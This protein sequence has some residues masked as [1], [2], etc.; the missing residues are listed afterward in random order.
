MRTYDHSLPLIVI[1]V[2]KTG[3][4][5]V[6]TF[7]TEWFGEDL[8][9]HYF[10]HQRGLMPRK[11]DLHAMNQIAGP[12]VVYGHFNRDRGFGVEDYY[13]DAK[14]FIAFLRDPFEQIVSGYF[15]VRRAGRAPACQSQFLQGGL[16][17]FVMGTNASALSFFPRQVSMENYKDIIEE[18]FI[19]IGVTE[20]FEES[21]MRIA[22]KIGQP[23]RPENVK[24]LNVS[25]RDQR[26][27]DELREEFMEKRPLDYAVYHY[28][29][30]RFT[31][32]DVAPAGNCAS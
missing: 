15:H 8:H 7:F 22:R 32:S 9:C 13:P 27:P 21:M 1:H 28:V 29:L 19:E 11:V 16:R 31:Q 30:A 18:F 14:Q 20:Y 26:V 6:K 5:S 25:P 24:R 23:Y 17:D 3:G 2:P 12:P 4:T 10:D